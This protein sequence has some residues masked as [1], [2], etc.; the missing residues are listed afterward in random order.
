MDTG[1]RPINSRRISLSILVGAVLIAAAL[2]MRFIVK[3]Q[4]GAVIQ[5]CTR[6]VGLRKEITMLVLADS[7]DAGWTPISWNV[8]GPPGPA[9]P[10]GETG[11]AGPQ[12]EIGP[13]G[14][15]GPAGSTGA[16]GQQGSPGTA[17]ITLSSP[18]E[19]QSRNGQVLVQDLASTSKSYCALE[20]VAIWD[21][22]DS[23]ETSFCE[24]YPSQ[25]VWHLKA[26][27]NG[28]SHADCRARCMVW[29]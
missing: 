12:G 4:S 9:G 23:S 27:S 26:V 5:G 3:A 16:T 15:Q 7:C 6:Q 1:I 2:P 14:P 19:L 25:G 10:Q 17:N 8:Q 28:D 21:S 20:K 18:V 29:P 13:A 24:V 11:P 22:E